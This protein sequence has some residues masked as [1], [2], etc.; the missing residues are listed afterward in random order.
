MHK[1]KFCARGGRT[2]SGTGEPCIRM[3]PSPNG[4]GESMCVI[5]VN[6]MNIVDT[7]YYKA[8]LNIAQTKHL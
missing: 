2:P 3:P 7:T 8:K 5:L 6:I 1:I 4:D